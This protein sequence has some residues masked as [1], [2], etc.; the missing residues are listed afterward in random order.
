MSIPVIA[1]A[2]SYYIYKLSSGEEHIDWY[3]ISV[4][5]TLSF[6]AAY[7]CIYFFLKVIERMGMF[8]FVVYRLLLGLGLFV[9]LLW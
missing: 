7:G 6:I 8:P 1:A 4:G 2:G 9:F 5:A 3:A